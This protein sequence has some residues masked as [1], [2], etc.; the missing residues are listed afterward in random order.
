M[1]LAAA[2]GAGGPHSTDTRMRKFAPLFA[3]PET[4]V[5]I[6]AVLLALIFSVGTQGAWLQGLPSV[7]RLTT[8]VGIIAVGQALL[9]TSG[10]VDLSVGSIFAITG[11][12][13]LTLMD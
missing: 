1:A 11:V 12:V 13:F 10:E 7:L 6:G 4:S 5:V 3:R 8:Q 9:M 2:P